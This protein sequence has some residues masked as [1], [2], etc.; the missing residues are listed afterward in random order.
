MQFVDDMSME[1]EKSWANIRAL[2]ASVL[3]FEMTW[4]KS[5]LPQSFFGWS[6]C[7]SNLVGRTN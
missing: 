4:F 5:G 2:K 6:Q 7:E 3:L 1:E